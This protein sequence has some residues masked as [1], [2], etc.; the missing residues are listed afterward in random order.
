[1]ENLCTLLLA[2]S[3]RWIGIWSTGGAGKTLTAQRVHNS[4]SVQE[5]FSGGVFWLTVGRDSSKK[6]LLRDLL[7]ELAVLIECPLS[8]AE[9]ELNEADLKNCLCGKLANCQK[10]LL[11]LDDV[12]QGQA[13]DWLDVLPRSVEYGN[14]MFVTTRNVEVLEAKHAAKF[15]IP[16]LNTKQSRMLFCFHAFPGGADNVP[17]ELQLVVEEVADE[18]KGLPLAL[19]VVGSA[20]TG[21]REA[22]QWQH[23]LNK[24]KSAET[25][26]PDHETQLF[27]R[28]ELSL[29][30][31]PR[32]HP[33]LR[34][35]FLYFAAFPEDF[36]VS[37]VSDLLDLWIGDGIIGTSTPSSQ[38]TSEDE[39]YE[40]LGWLIARSL[41]ELHSSPKN[42]YM[43]SPEFMTCKVHDVLRDLA[44]HTLHRNKA[45][46]DR[47]CLYEARR[48]LNEFPREWIASLTMHTAST[49]LSARRLSLA[50]NNLKELPRNLNAPYLQVLLLRD[51]EPLVYLPKSLIASLRNLRVLD[52]RNTS[53]SHLPRTIGNLK[54]L[55]VLNLSECSL[56]K[57]LPHSIGKLKN[58]RCLDISRCKGLAWLPSKM[59]Q[60]TN[61]QKLN[62]VAI[63]SAWESKKQT[64]ISSLPYSQ[65]AKLKDICSLSGLIQ[66]RISG[67]SMKFPI[68]GSSLN[69]LIDFKAQFRNLVE[70][71]DVGD[72]KSLRSLDLT[73]CFKLRTLPNSL[74]QLTNLISLNLTNCQPLTNLPALDSLPRLEILNLSGCVNV[75]L[76]S[77]FARDGGFPNLI[78]LSLV[79][80]QKANMFLSLEPGAMPNLTR[81]VLTGWDQLKSMP[82]NFQHLKK[83]RRLELDSCQHLQSLDDSLD[84][85]SLS[86]L[87]E[88][89][90]SNCRSLSALPPSLASLPNFKVLKV[91]NYKGSIPSEL[92]EQ[93]KNGKLQLIREVTS[94]DSHYT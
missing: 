76:P 10:V 43:A 77:S 13:L 78:E 41:I 52:I 69:K 2:E 34:D 72:L 73:G 83:L 20:L 53:I 62:L 1:M 11:F 67:E 24:L 66:L 15:P 74:V 16:M 88:L 93:E 35:C 31:L 63:A 65:R 59:F 28:L 32:L 26:S 4:K 75:E 50:F 33:R 48:L 3:E 84:L 27:A 18:C 8:P 17:A 51:N 44:R 54:L 45:P 38:K 23:A 71:P 94:K 56:L 9:F 46:Q 61:L 19:K 64:F 22:R 57:K 12:W 80:Y 70:L 90:V 5:H 21:K 37:M 87:E 29:D 55:A 89:N 25:L 85:Y 39:A 60:L 58:L 79:G 30:E 49:K 36:E 40:L 82:Q 92:L 47:E 81:L 42:K 91:I 68:Y 14:K 86:S 7:T 6:K